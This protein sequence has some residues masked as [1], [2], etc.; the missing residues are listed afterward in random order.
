MTWRRRTHARCRLLVTAL[1]TAA[2]GLAWCAASSQAFLYW[3]NSDVGTISI[4]RAELDGSGIEQG[5][6][7][8]SGVGSGPYHLAVDTHHI[9]WGTATS[10]GRA[11]LD[12]TAADPG[13]IKE[14]D[15]IGVAVDDE[16][17][18]W[19][20]LAHPNTI[21]RANLDGTEVD[22]SFIT[23]VSADSALAV[24]ATHIYWTDAN[25]THLTRSI[26][27][28]NIDG[29]EVEQRFIDVG[30]DYAW[31]VAVDAQ[32]L[33]WLCAGGSPFVVRICR[34]NIDGTGVEESF[35]NEV[36]NPTAL[37]VDADHLYWADAGTASIGRAG[38]DGS[39]VDPAF[40]TDLRGA[41]GLAVD[42]G[43]T[44]PPPTV[45]SVEPRFGGEAGGTSVAITGANLTAAT[46]VRFGATDAAYT[47]DSS[48]T[49][50]A[51]APSGTGTVDV[52]VTTA[53][54]TSA[55]SLADRFTYIPPGAPPTVT[56]VWPSHGPAT[57]GTLVTLSGTGFDGVTAVMFGDAPAAS[58]TVQSSTTIVALAPAGNGDVHVTVT[59]PNG[60]SRL[61]N[62]DRFKY[63]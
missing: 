22:P 5:F 48:S 58:F 39:N 12:G 60:T 21:G 62:K 38:L 63:R 52:T 24:D 6:I 44:V 1:A 25:N 55:I 15:A 42:L 14:V 45:T 46:A 18:Y 31:G 51:V 53:A 16:H 20:D 28:A 59:T 61:S 35:V 2:I 11:N 56:K 34:A 41:S 9:Y 8:T 37:A 29:T 32:H 43:R 3:G 4:G 17:V 50:T 19:T 30:A 57:G 7:G 13:F 49:I 36:S 27:R 54:G 47:V 10:L 33:Y 23:G 26:G 40:V